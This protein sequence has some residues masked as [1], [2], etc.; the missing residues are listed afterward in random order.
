MPQPPT[1]AILRAGHEERPSNR[2]F[3]LVIHENAVDLVKA[4]DRYKRPVGHG[5]VGCVHGVFEPHANGY[6]GVVRLAKGW[7]TG[8]I[9][10]HE[11]VHAACVVYRQDVKP[12][13]RLTSMAREE[14]LAYMQG[15]LFENV[16][17]I[18]LN[19]GLWRVLGE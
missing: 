8:E 15:I 3:Q 7:L 12:N 10:S 16:Q 11:M 9:V 13:V 2:W 6:S 4:A 5:C 1:R 19:L 17:T 18:L 14:D